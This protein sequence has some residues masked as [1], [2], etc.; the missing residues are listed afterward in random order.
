MI[1]TYVCV[2]G[3]HLPPD[4]VLTVNTVTSSQLYIWWEVPYSHNGYPIENYDIQILEKSSSD[5]NIFEN[6]P[7]YNETSYVYIFED[8]MQYCQIFIIIISAVNSLG[9][10]TP[11]SASR[12][13]PLRK[14]SNIFHVLH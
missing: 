11:G 13:F 3:P 14:M 7:E 8:D 9:S 10:S 6:V 12:G 2:S 5:T 1:L 4:P